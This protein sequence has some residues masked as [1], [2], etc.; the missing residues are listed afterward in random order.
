MA[1]MFRSVLQ[2]SG[3]AAEL[4][5]TCAEEFAGE[6]IS[7]SD[8]T[9]T[10]TKT[11]PSSSP[12]TVTF[13]IP[14]SG[15]WT[16]SATV[17][18]TTYTSDPITVELDYTAELNYGFNWKT[19][20]IAGGLDPT[21]YT[22]LADLL[23]DEK[24]L[25]RLFL[26]HDAVDY[27][28]SSAAVNA[29]LATVINTDLAAKWINLS[30]YALDTLYANTE[31]A[32]EM[33]TAD[34]YFYGEWVITDSTTTPVTWGPKGNVPVMTSNTAPYGTAISQSVYS[35]YEPYKAF[36][37]NLSDTAFGT[38]TAGTGAGAYLGYKFTN[39]INVKR[40]R[41]WSGS[42]TTDTLKIQYSDDG[43]SWNDASNT[44]TASVAD[45]YKFID[46]NDVGYHLYWA[47]YKVSSIAASREA[48]VSLQFYGRELK[49]SVPTMTSNTAPYGE[50]SAINTASDVKTHDAYHAFCGMTPDFGLGNYYWLTKTA[51]S[52]V[53]YEFEKKVVAKLVTLVTTGE[54]SGVNISITVSGVKNGVAT[55]IDST[56]INSARGTYSFLVLDN[57]N[58]YDT[59]RLT[60]NSFPNGLF[61]C[62]LLQFYGLDYSEKE[63]E[64]GTTKK[65]LYDH[66][67]ELETVA[68][69]L[70]SNSGNEYSKDSNELYFKCS[71]TNS[72][73]GTYAEAMWNIDLAPYS[74]IRAAIGKRQYSPTTG[75]AGCMINI[76]T[77][78][79]Q[80]PSGG[81]QDSST[82]VAYY[83][84]VD[85]L[86][87]L[88][89]A[90]IA[91]DIST[92]NDDYL[93]F[94]SQYFGSH[95]ASLAELWLE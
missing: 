25:R 2:N 29:D 9:T 64:V 3:G 52:Y 38:S 31:I 11:C 70:G 94:G 74:L 76:S 59:Y 91:F 71:S 35:G 69:R 19:W 8:G 78:D 17:G 53:Q 37:N 63:F 4:I 90:H 79:A 57:D 80:F 13:K 33:E 21:D 18:G 1:L 54:T 92:I 47:V 67:V 60:V 40:V 27:M 95:Y 5:V 46:I 39:P 36:D 32:D 93:F 86:S 68:F 72:S 10:L 12:Y 55:D 30:D 20:V 42:S 50:A 77:S 66:G 49:V 73:Y 81:S 34:K 7:C 41:I 24:A 56:M 45:N 62:G 16:I 28:A 89:Y 26:V 85:S 15:N 22:D 48:I 82:R 84:V 87:D 6:T 61:A 23:T 43:S 14:N 51:N 58:D 88:P 44:F 83:G 65:W 75:G